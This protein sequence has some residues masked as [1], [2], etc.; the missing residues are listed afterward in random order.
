MTT[1][2]LNCGGQLYVEQLIYCDGVNVEDIISGEYSIL[3]LNQMLDS[4]SFGELF[5]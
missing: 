5:L 2:C 3:E 4:Q 1:K